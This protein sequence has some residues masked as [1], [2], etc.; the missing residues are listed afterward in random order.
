MCIDCGIKQG[1]LKHWIITSKND[2]FNIEWISCIIWEE[3]L[4]GIIASKVTL[5][6][7]VVDRLFS[8]EM[9]GEKVSL[10]RLL[11]WLWN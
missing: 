9:I 3:L 1:L 4:L 5:Q 7:L 8:V 6:L 11:Q 2:F 10:K